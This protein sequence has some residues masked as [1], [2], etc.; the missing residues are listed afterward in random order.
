MLRGV[1]SPSVCEALTSHALKRNL[2]PPN[3]INTIRDSIV[4]T[5]IKFCSVAVKVLLA[6]V[7]VDALHAAFKDAVKALNGIGVDL[8]L[9]APRV[10]AFAVGGEVVARKFVCKFG[11]LLCFVGEYH[12][13][14]SNVFAQDR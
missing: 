14:F 9:L 13:L 2:T 4:V 10:F 1:V 5:E 8:W 7:L 6:A 11:V 3:I 12:C